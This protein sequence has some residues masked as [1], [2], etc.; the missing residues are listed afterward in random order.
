MKTQKEINV[1]IEA[2]KTVRPKVQSCSMFGDDNLAAVD[3]Q[4]GVLE[5]G[6][7]DDDIYDRHDHADSSEHVLDAALEARQWVDGTSES[8]SLATDWPLKEE[9]SDEKKG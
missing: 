3:A 2:L 9:D 5:N 8:D 7:D 4:I 6:W 1:E